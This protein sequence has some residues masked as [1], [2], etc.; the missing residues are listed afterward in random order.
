[1]ATSLARQLQKLAAPQTDTF[2]HQGRKK[3]S[4]LFEAGEAANYDI[5]DIYG[6]GLGGLQELQLLNDAFTTFE[7]TLFAEVSQSIERSVQTSD[8][9]KQL[10]ARI[11]EFLRLISPYVMVRPAQKAIE[12]LLV[13]FHIHQYNVGDLMLC[14]LPY[15]E[16]NI[17][18]RMVQLLEFQ[19][20]KK[21]EWLK[22]I[23]KKG[24][25]LPKKDLLKFLSKE[26]W[27]QQFL[28]EELSQ[29][30][31]SDVPVA[32]NDVFGKFF[33]STLIALLYFVQEVDNALVASI[34]PCMGKCLKSSESD[35]R[36][37]A[38]TVI[39]TLNQQTR[40]KDATYKVLITVIG[41]SAAKFGDENGIKALAVILTA[42][43]EQKFSEEFFKLFANEG[44]VSL[45]VQTLK[46][47]K[48]EEFLLTLM[49]NLVDALIH[50]ENPYTSTVEKLLEKTIKEVWMDDSLKKTIVRYSVGETLKN[51]KLVVE[52][53]PHL[54]RCLAKMRELEP[55]TWSFLLNEVGTEN[56]NLLERL[57]LVFVQ[58]ADAVNLT[59]LPSTTSFF[60]RLNHPNTA[61]RLDAVTA[62]LNEEDAM[63]GV[64][65]EFTSNMIKERFS[66]VDPNVVLKVLDSASLLEK[67]LSADELKELLTKLLCEVSTKEIPKKWSAVEAKALV[68]LM[69]T[70]AVCDVLPFFV[71]ALSK[72]N[73]KVEECEELRAMFPTTLSASHETLAMSELM[74]NLVGDFL[75]K[76]SD[77]VLSCVKS[78][79]TL[80]SRPHFPTSAAV[81]TIT[82]LVVIIG[83]LQIFFDSAEAASILDCIASLMG[84]VKLGNRKLN[85]EYLEQALH[86]LKKHK[87]P[88]AV[89]LGWCS[90][91]FQREVP[92][93]KNSST[94][95]PPN[96][97][98]L[99][100]AA[101]FVLDEV[102]SLTNDNHF[103]EALVVVFTC[104]VVTDMKT[105]VAL[106]PCVMGRQDSKQGFVRDVLFWSAEAVRMIKEESLDK[107]KVTELLSI[108]VPAMRHEDTRM[109]MGGLKLI[110]SVME[111]HQ[112]QDVPVEKLFAAILEK[113]DMIE[114]DDMAITQ[115]LGDLFTTSPGES[116]ENIWLEVLLPKGF[117][118]DLIKLNM[119][120]ALR[121]VKPLVVFTRLHET[122][123]WL[124]SDYDKLDALQIRILNECLERL[125]TQSFGPNYPLVSNDEMEKLVVQ[126][127]LAALRLPTRLNVRG[128]SEV[129]LQQLFFMVPADVGEEL[130]GKLL[131][132]IMTIY[133]DK[134]NPSSRPA[135]R[136]FL[137]H[138]RIPAKL[139]VDQL[140]GTPAISLPPTK[141]LSKG[142]ASL[143]DTQKQSRTFWQRVTSV[144]DL[145]QAKKKVSDPYLLLK[146]LFELAKETVVVQEKDKM[147]G[148]GR[149]VGGEGDMVEEEGE[150]KG[151]LIEDIE[152]ARRLIFATL[153]FHCKRLTADSS[154]EKVL[155][156]TK[157][158]DI[159]AIVKCIQSSADNQTHLAALTLLSTL[160]LIVP[161]DVIQ[162]C[163]TIFTLSG[164]RLL[165]KDDQYSV[166]VV[167]R[168]IDVIV[169]VMMQTVASNTHNVVRNIMELFVD[170]LPHIPVQRRSFLFRR[171]LKV[172]N[173]EE[174][175]WILVV[176]LMNVYVFK[177][178][179]ID[180]NNPVKRK[181]YPVLCEFLEQLFE[182]L[183]VTVQIANLQQATECIWF[184]LALSKPGEASQP[185]RKK[186]SNVTFE[187]PLVSAD[188]TTIQLISLTTAVV[189]FIGYQVPSLANQETQKPDKALE[190]LL[191]TLLDIQSRARTASKVR[192]S[193]TAIWTD[194]LSR[195]SVA[196][197]EILSQLPWSAFVPVMLNLLKEAPPVALKT[198]LEELGGSL[199]FREAFAEGDKP[200]LL[201]LVETLVGLAKKH[202]DVSV[203][204]NASILQGC[205]FCL[206]KLAAILGTHS[207]QVWT[208]ILTQSVSLLD[209]E[210][211][212]VR[213]EAL[214]CLTAVIVSVKTAVLSRLPTFLPTLLD[215]IQDIL[216][217]RYAESVAVLAAIEALE[218]VVSFLASFISP[219]LAKILNVVAA[220]GNASVKST[221]KDTFAVKVAKIRNVLTETVPFRV[222]CGAFAANK[223]LQEEI[224]IF[225]IFNDNLRKAK[226][227]DVLALQ[228]EMV[229][230]LFGLFEK[231]A[232]IQS[233]AME[234]LTILALRM[235]EGNFRSLFMKMYQWATQDAANT[236]RLLTFYQAVN[237]L[238]EALKHL[239]TIFAATVISHSVS[240]MNKSENV[241]DELLISIFDVLGKFFKY[242]SGGYFN[243]DQFDL[244]MQPLV[245][246]LEN[247]DESGSYRRRME[248]LIPTVVAFVA[249]L[250]DDSLWKPLHYQVCLKTRNDE[251]EVRVAALKTIEALAENLGEAYGNLL[252]EAVT[253]L[254]ELSAEDDDMVEAQCARTKLTLEKAIGD[255]ELWKNEMH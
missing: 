26:V 62:L 100:R 59:D 251:A 39:A 151:S 5:Q 225:G 51:K 245:D 204:E 211:I 160:A 24:V 27:F 174:N 153:N 219:Y 98:S 93:R 44:F 71:T 135:F 123:D 107:S 129:L 158:L 162:H 104:S 109:R 188:F 128:P 227:A 150:E 10:D 8:V 38:Y 118:P 117:T 182:G 137:K 243:S 252:P 43:E 183:D 157:V 191:S 36:L 65:E 220:C 177:G 170:T 40:I 60:L 146:E 217:K 194:L 187:T 87:L 223:E 3:A 33:A 61:V 58:Q 213:S 23:Q 169:P 239:F 17:F 145:V 142:L 13:R 114:M 72:R 52:V 237:K 108:A 11:A 255:P 250:N 209:S 120:I 202:K 103:R 186:T 42:Q 19:F 238:T 89:V 49:R 163:M 138:V 12:W 143:N 234:A 110:G 178:L 192:N 236:A 91:L 55:V 226:T 210:D 77:S 148:E 78:L 21:W 221:V 81:I 20:D 105:L 63:E 171:L 82:V 231:T 130:Y 203:P 57:D 185:K 215:Q 32:S 46:V 216:S 253:F 86:H 212:N 249:C 144:L 127:M 193:E 111:R 113:R 112:F 206:R 2:L 94:Q 166:E 25:V 196:V 230:M 47:N 207:A 56:D 18:V 159:P 235:P 80:M 96:Q 69:K 28:C 152:M 9:N 179:S 131:R 155:L 200:R 35:Y 254:V 95:R 74:E 106:L 248:H 76:N 147:E 70:G 199:G 201:P 173:G 214:N 116:T 34:L 4:L 232:L 50:E 97:M 241:N 176:L 122:V 175:L 224:T 119:L 140:N 133:T 181:S 29:R 14:F 66:D 208:S 31:T 180:D 246:Q 79:A 189:T 84:K 198:A 99:L 161:N 197:T 1:M 126:P 139:I 134:I 75:A 125:A 64:G 218:V 149:S 136:K 48:M 73:H 167:G 41:E 233:E 184:V 15:H 85:E 37:I 168:T 16:T 121:L 229:E 247:F 242:D 6:I 90:L 101:R 156:G 164:N 154:Q 240:L 92:S 67:K 7:S 83:R 195:S 141:R 102:Y 244:L 165:N 172:A 132:E 124:I 88:A 228:R 222:M 30:A 190:Q 205:L 68:A 54:A 22:G 53:E 45:L 115:L